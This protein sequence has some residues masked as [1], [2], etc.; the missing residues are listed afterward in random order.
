LLD[1]QKTMKMDLSQV[2]LVV[3]DMDGTLLNSEGKVSANFLSLFEELKRLDLTFVAASG[4][5]YHSIVDKLHMIKDEIVIIAENGGITKQGGV[6]LQYNYF[7]KEEVRHLVPLLRNI[8]DIYP[9]IC[10]ENKAYIETKEERFINLLSEYYSSFELV[11]DLLDVD[12]DN[13]FKIAVYNFENSEKNIYPHLQHLNGNI[14]VK[15]SGRHWVDLS[16]I[17]THKGFALKNLQQ[18]LNVSEEETMVFGDYNNDL[19]M[20]SL[21]YYSFAMENAHPNVKNT[22][23]FVTKSNDEEGVETILQQLIK[24]KKGIL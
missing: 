6:T 10:G 14:Q 11:D 20:L 12:N 22:A 3:T 21:A 15:V 23:R 7:P 24:E 16:H 19:E 13:F 2:K 4:R 1:L 17:N 18:Q 5:Q 9:V 8:K